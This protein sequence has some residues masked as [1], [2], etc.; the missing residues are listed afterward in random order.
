VKTFTLRVIPSLASTGFTCSRISAC[1]T[2]VA[3]TLSVVSACAAKAAKAN[4]EAMRETNWIFIVSSF[5]G[6]GVVTGL[7]R[8]PCGPALNCG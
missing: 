7:K 3:A 8:F 5:M 6:I 4:A 1:G 2:A